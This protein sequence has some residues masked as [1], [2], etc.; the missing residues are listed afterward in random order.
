MKIT[1]WT[2][3]LAVSLVACGLM[4]PLTQAADLQTNLVVNP[5]FENIDASTPGPFTS[6]SLLDWTDPTPGDTTSSEGILGDA[7]AYPY[8]SGYS[9]EP[10]PPSAGLHHFAG[11]FNTS[12]S[13]V[14]VAQTV[15]LSGGATGAAIAAGVARFDLT[16]FFSTYFTQS[17][18]SSV[19][20]SF[21]NGSGASLGVST[22]GG[23]DFLLGLPELGGRRFWGQDRV[24][25]LV[26]VGSASAL[27]EVVSSGGG[28]NYDGYVDLLDLTIG[29]LPDDAGLMLQV[30]PATGQARMRN[31]TGSEV[32]I[33]YYEVTSA[34]GSLSTSGWSSFDVQNL[35]GD[36][37]RAAGAVSPAAIGE[38]L[39][40]DSTTI[41]DAKSLPLG[42]PFN[43]S[44]PQDLVF[45]YGTPEGLL[46]YG[47]V[48]YAPI[49]NVAGDYNGD[50]VV[51]AAD[52][53]VWRDTLGSVSDLRADGNGNQQI[54]PGDRAVWVS[55]Y[56][57]SSA[58]SAAAVPEPVGCSLIVVSAGLLAAVSGQ[59]RRF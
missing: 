32:A 16:G 19:R 45:R 5:G 25:G 48:K 10:N 55:N 35:Q 47:N 4:A 30:D 7:Y 57:R 22:I 44:L 59:R 33:S 26:P 11:G 23:Q 43:P 54:D 50:Q 58:S 39:L 3:M 28:G 14:Q 37:W 12:P 29:G 8:A 13:E 27:V 49:V 34:A 51:D 2:R 46:L 17:D 1:N 21:R 56:G 6:V 9:G 36:D 31:L 40:L 18:A 20:V 42:A 24:S 53:T 52:Y 38:S 15:A 41:G